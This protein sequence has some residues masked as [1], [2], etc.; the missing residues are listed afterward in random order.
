M[1]SLK[2]QNGQALVEFAI[3]LPIL[4][5][6]VMGILQFGMMLNSYLAIENATREGARAGIVGKSDFEI[7]NMIIAMSPSLDPQNIV[8]T[9]NPTE[10]SRKSG[11]T[12]VVKITYNYELTVPI[13]SSLFNNVIVLNGQ[14]SMRIE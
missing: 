6:L 7:K 11:D 5:I 13:I 3:I 1:K 2:N 9:I 4:L 8:I 14:T 12:L 10:N